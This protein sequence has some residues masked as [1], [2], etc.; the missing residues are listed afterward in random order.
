M[1][2]NDLLTAVQSDRVRFVT[3]SPPDSKFAILERVVVVT[4][5][6]ELVALSQTPE[7]RVL[8]ELVPLLKDRD[9]AW[10][11]AVLLAAMTGREAKFIDSFAAKPE[12]WWD[13]LGP[14]AFERWS[15]WLEENR[16]N[17]VWDPENHMF[18]E[19]D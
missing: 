14:T 4:E 11:A 7:V 15:K 8:E 18:V 10:A 5:P 12:Q 19:R 13:V 9:K 6:A 17:L 2:P 3:M 16:G 1:Q